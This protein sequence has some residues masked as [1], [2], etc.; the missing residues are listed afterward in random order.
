V[1]EVKWTE[2]S[3]SVLHYA[4]NLIRNFHPHLNDARIC[5]VFRSE[6][7]KQG[8]RMIL[9]QAAK[10][11]AKFMPY[12]EYDFIIWLSER[13]YISMDDLS[14]EALIDHEL[15]HC[16]GNQ[17]LGW[18]IRPHDIQEF[19]DV[20]Q[21]HGCW[22]PDVRLAKSALNQY[23]MQ[24]LPGLVMDSMNNLMNAAEKAGAE[25]VTISGAGKVVTLT[26]EQLDRAAKALAD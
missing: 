7:Q 26:G 18:K 17:W 19:S 23:E 22:A 16:S 12:L 2:A 5:F 21:R 14:R 4:E 25:Q 6:A 11:P 24:T 1:S 9:G 10:V 15:C 20:I 8:E 3:P 13:D